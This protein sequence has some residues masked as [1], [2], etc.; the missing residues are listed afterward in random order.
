VTPTS[1]TSL[2]GHTASTTDAA[3]VAL[4]QFETEWVGLS[5]QAN[6]APV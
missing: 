4:E 1:C 3:E 5:L 6:S 2:D